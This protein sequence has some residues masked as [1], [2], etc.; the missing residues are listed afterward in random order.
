MSLHTRCFAKVPP[1]APACGCPRGLLGEV[2]CL[3]GHDFPGRPGSRGTRGTRGTRDPGRPRGHGRPR[4]PGR[5]RGPGGPG[6]RG[7]RATRGAPETRGTR[8]TRGTRATWGT[9]GTRGGGPED[10]PPT[11]VCPEV[12]KTTSDFR[13]PCGRRKNRKQK[14][15]KTP[16]NGHPSMNTPQWA[17]FNG[18]LSHRSLARKGLLPGSCGPAD[19][20]K[21]V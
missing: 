16:F 4:K 19:N 9:R 10:R 17:P 11:A 12:R 7:I 18:R 1:R 13:L 21:N 20:S 14:E 6:S 5:T 8:G 2:W 15:N 3:Q